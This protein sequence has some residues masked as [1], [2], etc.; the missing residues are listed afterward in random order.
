MGT[1]HAALAAGVPLVCVPGGRDQDDVAARVVFRGAGVRVR[2]KSPA[3]IG[4]AVAKVLADESFAES[5]RGIARA[6]AEENGA[7][8][9]VD[10]IEALPA[11]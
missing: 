9:A 7:S 6:L 4:R 11:V 3:R 10:A 1:V 2:R 5:A 8:A